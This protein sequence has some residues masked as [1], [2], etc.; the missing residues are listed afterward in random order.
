MCL[1]M[2]GSRAGCGMHIAQPCRDTPLWAPRLM[3]QG[4]GLSMLYWSCRAPRQISLYSYQAYCYSFQEH[5][6]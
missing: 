2:A 1:F 5:T 4:S 6:M 3:Y